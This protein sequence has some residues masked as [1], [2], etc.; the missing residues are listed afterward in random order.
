MPRSKTEVVSFKADATLLDAMRGV[1]NRSEFIRTAILAALDSTCP[2]CSGT[3]T[4][5]PNQMRHWNEL[6]TDHS[7]EECEDCREVRLVCSNREEK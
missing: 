6:A 2:L 4:L 5:T 3:G 7:V 1:A